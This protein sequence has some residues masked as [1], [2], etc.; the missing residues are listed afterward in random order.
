MT[1][2]VGEADGMTVAQGEAS[3]S[4][5]NP[6]IT[7]EIFMWGASTNLEQNRV[8]LTKEVRVLG[9]LT[10]FSGDEWVLQDLN[11][12]RIPGF[13]SLA[14]ASPWATIMPSAKPTA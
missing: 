12:G 8:T 6:G 13:R 11:R 5:R 3:A 14:L 10:G 2:P 7:R 1:Q 4:E 9:R